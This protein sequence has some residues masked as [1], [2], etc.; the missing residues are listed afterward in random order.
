MSID[1]NRLAREA[2]RLKF[3]K[4][5]SSKS[6]EPWRGLPR[7]QRLWLIRYYKLRALWIHLGHSLNSFPRLQNGPIINTPPWVDQHHPVNRKLQEVEDMVKVEYGP[8]WRRWQMYKVEYHFITDL[9]EG[10]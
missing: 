9:N 5:N 10:I 7:W 1:Y 3:S 4:L 6:D 8:S 2:R